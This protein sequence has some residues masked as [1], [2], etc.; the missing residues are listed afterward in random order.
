MAKREIIIGTR[1]SDLA[2]WQANFTKDKLER[3]GYSVRL[4]IIKTKGDRI[5]HLSF[6]KIEG[7]GFFTREIE[8]ALLSG[9][10]DLA[11]H[12]CKDM[13]T[14]S[15]EGLKLAAF[16]ARVSPLDVLMV[17]REAYDRTQFLH[18]AEGAVT[19]TSSARRKAQLLAFRP[20]LTIKD[21]RGNVPTRLAK[22]REGQ[23]DAILLAAAGLDRLGPDLSGLVRID[24]PADQFVPAPAQG[25]LAYQVRSDDDAMNAA[26]AVLNDEA[27]HRTAEVERRAL[28]AFD[29]G[30]QVPLGI[31]HEVRNGLNHLWVSRAKSATGVPV[32][33]HFSGTGDDIRPEA[34]LRRMDGIRPCSVFISRETGSGDYFYR[35]LTAH[36]FRVEGRALI[37]FEPLPFQA[38]FEAVDWLFF[39]SGNGVRYFFDKIADLPGHIRLG[40][41]NAGTARALEQTGRQAD[42][43]GEGGDLAAIAAA[44]D[45]TEG[46]RVLFA[47][48]ETSNRSI[49]RNLKQKEI[50]EVIVYRNFPVD[51]VPRR[52]EDILVFTSPM[53][54]RNYLSRHA[55]SAGQRLLAIG[56]S[57]GEAIAEF[58][59]DCAEAHGPMPWS[60]AD[61]VFRLSAE[62]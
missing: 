9:E 25:I 42:F 45:D 60:L 12:S 1:G 16:S 29:G 32:R 39:T 41:V 47:R 62:A 38:S 54:A 33:M 61:S 26:L 52:E 51:E 14:E 37:D 21:I 28:A 20:D 22:L 5:Q 35:V 10:V 58:G 53:N 11:V 23:F 13:P 55:L 36:G 7:K 24:L 50:S 59:Q 17:R 48:A 56:P 30:C 40:A 19:G 31:Y 6:D 44:F 15:P 46:K 49:Q 8:D 4:R 2:L 3:A 57:T 43:T 34:V 18:L 27:G